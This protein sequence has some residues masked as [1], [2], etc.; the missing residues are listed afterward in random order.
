M[1]TALAVLLLP[2][3]ATSLVTAVTLLLGSADGTAG[4]N[5]A[6]ALVLIGPAA[7]VAAFGARIWWPRLVPLVVAASFFALVMVGRA[8]IA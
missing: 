3:I 4:P 7:T 8:L 6:F 5:R 1:L 2:L